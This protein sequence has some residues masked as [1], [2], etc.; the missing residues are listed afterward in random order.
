MIARRDRA[1]HSEQHVHEQLM[2]LLGGRAAEAVAYGHVSSGAADDLE[3]ANAIA[4]HAVMDLGFSPR[5]GQL[6]G[7]AAGQAMPLAEST[8]QVIDEEVERM[9]ADAYRDAIAM[10]EQHRP[11]LEALADALLASEDLD[12]ERIAALLGSG[13]ARMA[14]RPDLG[15]RPEPALR[16]QNEPAQALAPVERIRPARRRRPAVA[17]AAS[18]ARSVVGAGLTR[19]KSGAG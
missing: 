18:L 9:I 10:V 19:V 4:R 6:T 13:R 16:R 17:A 14:A 8:R 2:V 5:A 15:P 7:S 11:E 1:L 12:R 3:R